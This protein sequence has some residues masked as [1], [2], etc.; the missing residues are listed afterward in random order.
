VFQSKGRLT[1]D[2]YIVEVR[3][4]FKS[5]K[6]QSSD[7]Q[8]WGLNIV[9]A[10]Q[11]SGNE[12]SWTPARRSGLSFLA[13]SGALEGLTDLRRGLVVDM[14]PELTQRT[15]GTPGPSAVGGWGYD[16]QRP[17]LG[18]NLRWG[19]TNNLTLNGTVNPD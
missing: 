3:I 7:V 16:R 6:Y 14:N 17:E 9:R 15:A 2:G 5:L 19:V 1:A 4:P 11:H 13:Q 18:G 8:S 10:V 12:D